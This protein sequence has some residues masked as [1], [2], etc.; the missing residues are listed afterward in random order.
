M[1]FEDLRLEGN[2]LT[3][4]LPG[5]EGRGSMELTVVI[6]GDAFEGTAEFGPRS[7]KVTGS[8]TSGPDGGDS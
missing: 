5:R 6:T 8:R 7:V 2:M 4:V 3:V 1:A